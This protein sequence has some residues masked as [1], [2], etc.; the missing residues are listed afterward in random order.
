MTAPPPWRRAALIV[1]A[2][3]RRGA[4]LH[5]EAGR[6]LQQAGVPLWLSRAERDPARMRRHVEQAIADGADLVIVGGGDG[7][8]SGTV[9]AL[10][11]TSAVFAPLPLG[12]AN[13]FARTL[14]TGADLGAAVAAIAAGRHARIDIAEIDG[15]MFANSASL[16]L[17][18]LIGDTI[19]KWLKG[20]LGRFGYLVWALRTMVRF[21]PFQLHVEADAEQFSGWATELRMLNGQFAGG[22]R[23]SD[24]ADLGSGSLN[25]QIICGKSRWQLAIDWYRRMLGL[26]GHAAA[27]T[28]LE[29][30]EARI[31]AL[32]VQKV[33]I[34]GEV[35]ARTPFRLRLHPAAVSVVVPSDNGPSTREEPCRNLTVRATREGRLASPLEDTLIN[36]KGRP[37]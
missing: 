7:S 37:S 23:V 11:G 4:R 30:R 17:S 33:S 29:V 9:G 1:N 12:T 19:P 24:E 3:S 13:S 6:L 26:R 14:G 15:H 16:G 8:I 28:E 2:R 21:K 36:S 10:C 27:V 5:K 31:S 18:P 35:L 25:L 32:P 20:R 34:D 22:V